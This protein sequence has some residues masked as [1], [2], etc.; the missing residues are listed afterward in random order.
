M[1]STRVVEL[2]IHG[3]GGSNREVMLGPHTKPLSADANDD[4]G[5]WQDT[6][7]PKTA[8]DPDEWQ[9]F[10]WGAHIPWQMGV[11]LVL[12]PF[13]LV[14]A[15]GWAIEAGTP[16]GAGGSH[17]RRRFAA[18]TS[19]RLIALLGLALTVTWTFWMV[20]IVGD[21]LTYNGIHNHRFDAGWVLAVAIVAAVLALVAAVVVQRM[22]KRGR[23]IWVVLLAGIAVIALGNWWD[24]GPGKSLLA[25]IAAAIATAGPFVIAGANR[26]QFENYR[27]RLGGTGVARERRRLAD[28]E[29]LASPCF[30]D[31]PTDSIGLLVLHGLV[32][33][34]TLAVLGAR[35]WV[36]ALDGTAPFRGGAFIPIGLGQFAVM[37]A[38]LIVAIV[39]TSRTSAGR[40]KGVGN[41][42]LNSLRAPSMATIGVLAFT[43]VIGCI[44][45]ALVGSSNFVR[46][47]QL[48]LMSAFL[49]ASLAALAV[50]VVALTL[51]F[52]AS[53]PAGEGAQKKWAWRAD[54]TLRWFV[55]HLDWLLSMAGVVISCALFASIVFH[56][57]EAGHSI[58]RM[59]PVDA[60]FAPWEFTHS[61]VQPLG[62]AMLPMPGLVTFALWLSK[63]HL[64]WAGPLRSLWDV[65]GFWPRRFHPLGVPPEA[66]RTVPELQSHLLRTVNDR[67]CRVL[68][69]GHSQGSVIAW[70]ALI[71]MRDR[72][73]VAHI[74]LVTAGS[75]LFALYPRMFPAQVAPDL[76]QELA[77]DLTTDG[78]HRWLNLSR[79]TDYFGIAPDPGAGYAIED[80]RV[81]MAGVGEDGAFRLLAHGNYF[82][83]DDVEA[84]ATERVARLRCRGIPVR[85]AP[86]PSFAPRR[87]MVSW[88]DPRLLALTAYKAAVS[89]VFG[90]WAD[91]RQIEALQTDDGTPAPVGVWSPPDGVWLDFVA[92]EGDA[93]DPT[94]LVARA[95]AHPELHVLDADGNDKVLP[96]GDVLV[97]GG[98]EVYPVAGRPRYDNQLLGPY[99][100]AASCCTDP[101][102]PVQPTMLVLPGNHD[103]Y[104]GLQSFYEL[105]CT[106]QDVGRWRTVQDRSYWAARL[107]GPGELPAWWLWGVDLQLDNEFDH[108]QWAYFKTMAHHLSPD[109]CIILCSPI[110]TW[111]HSGGDPMAFDE[112]K[113]L[114]QLAHDHGGRVV[115][116]L[117]GDSHHYAR[118][119]RGPVVQNDAPVP[120]SE[121]VEAGGPLPTQ[122][123]TSG[124]GGAFTHP[125]HGLWQWIDL[126]VAYEKENVELRLRSRR[127]KAQK[128]RWPAS[129]RDSPSRSSR[130]LIA[131]NV[132]M[133]LVRNPAF[134]PIPA[135]VC[136]LAALATWFSAGARRGHSPTLGQFATQFVTAWAA[137]VLSL[138]VVAGWTAFAKPVEGGSRTSARLVGFFHGLA[139]AAGMLLASWVAVRL[140][141]RVHHPVERWLA[142]LFAGEKLPVLVRG[143]M[144]RLE[145]TVFAAVIGAVLACVLVGSYLWLTNLTL[146]MHD[147]E[148][149]SAMASQKH[150]HFVRIHIEGGQATCWVL[151]V[152][153]SRAVLSPFESHD[154]RP[155]PSPAPDVVLWDRFRVGTAG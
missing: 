135:V 120:L 17:G 118:Y 154:P 140:W 46:H 58:L 42:V 51:C 73:A 52:V 53:T 11:W 69:V 87:R 78:T 86:I 25:T 155:R 18:Q 116:H 27:A 50:T 149:A 102:A 30:F 22:A 4:S 65:L 112:L 105:F 23:W 111:A 104:D 92:D 106:G 61:W 142:H 24:D 66:E 15:A 143:G 41:A 13:T 137:V 34:A 152:N 39:G 84:A 141:V 121:N 75:P 71:G 119:E 100:L 124:G 14:N 44:D 64:T 123:V 59:R 91:A 139:Q 103:W 82:R 57:Y 125:T 76:L 63:D 127:P 32:A 122:Y 147:N 1:D 12:L 128:L 110:P 131:G 55:A 150:K 81:S 29:T 132:A 7:P 38:L 148:A 49:T 89:I 79:Q 36:H 6:D 35:A 68:I 37:T 94:F 9:A 85:P 88:F 136:G 145:L 133:F 99:A 129:D 8:E 98:D 83:A 93:F 95:L 33:A 21:T 54:R 153:P 20:T 5:F 108:N 80:K 43:A 40:P 62:W 74:D 107:T 97:L 48:E 113:R 151:G 77:E 96:C 146:D 16:V 126:P 60:S 117:S 3:V 31:H 19:R 28:E 70:S 2:R 26:Q 114:S 10:L 109:D 115:L 90:S 56:R 144:Q 134:V 67:K 101:C 47:P 45:A 72:R 130:R 138:L